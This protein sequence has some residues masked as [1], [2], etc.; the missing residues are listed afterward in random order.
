M[1][2]AAVQKTGVLGLIGLAFLLGCGS[3][4]ESPSVIAGGSGAGNPGATVSLSMAVLIT[5]AA[6]KTTAV[7]APAKTVID[8]CSSVTTSD[9]GGTSISLN[10]ILLSGIIIHFLVDSSDRP[11]DLLAAMHSRPANLSCDSNSIILAPAES[12]N[13]LSDSSGSGASSILLPIARY[14][15]VKLVFPQN[16]N[17]AQAL[18][19]DTSG[20]QIVMNGTFPYAGQIHPL[21]VHIAYAQGPCSQTYSFAGGI[22]TLSSSD[23][24]HLE[25]QFTANQWFS[26]INVATG[27]QN[28]DYA[29]DNCGALNFTNYSCQSSVAW[30]GATVAADFLSSGKLTVY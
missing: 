11:S 25:L 7:A 17:S 19:N 26:A 4:T 3:L 20:S 5:S 16:T 12:F 1:I 18:E 10:N 2:R 24:T 30:T 23:T 15:G 8:S 6:A 27:L 22:F 21:S 29:F 13:A 28:G 14:S 9:Q